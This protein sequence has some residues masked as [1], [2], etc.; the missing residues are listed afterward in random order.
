MA[1][2]NAMESKFYIDYCK[3]D[4]VRVLKKNIPDKQAAIEIAQAY[5]EKYRAKGKSGFIS[6]FTIS[7]E[8]G[9]PMQK[10]YEGYEI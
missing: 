9:A 10:L 7:C 6:I 8:R 3:G 5:L 2:L 4:K 1:K